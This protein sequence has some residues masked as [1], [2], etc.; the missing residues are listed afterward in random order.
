MPQLAQEKCK[1]AGFVAAPGGHDSAPD[2]L[3]GAYGE[4][5]DAY[6]QAHLAHESASAFP[7]ATA[8]QA[9]GDGDEQGSH[10]GQYFPMG[11]DA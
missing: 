5:G 9:A 1:F 8:P 4:G 7:A 2:H 6:A 3:G 11:L 10:Q